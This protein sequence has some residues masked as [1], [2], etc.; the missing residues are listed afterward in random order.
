[1]GYNKALKLF[2]NTNKILLIY[3]SDFTNKHL[4]LREILLSDPSVE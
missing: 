4:I 3:K 2:K 1:M